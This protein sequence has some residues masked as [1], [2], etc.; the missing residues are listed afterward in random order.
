MKHKI[1]IT[2]GAGFIGSN[3]TQEL[4]KQGHNVTALDNRS[5]GRIENNEEFFKDENYRLIKGSVTDLQLLS[6]EF[7]GVEY[8][9]HQAAV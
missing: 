8:E 6:K 7:T 2:G 3:L 1:L 5:M 9:C 4:L